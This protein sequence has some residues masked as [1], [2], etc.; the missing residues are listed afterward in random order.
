MPCVVIALA[1]LLIP[2]PVMAARLGTAT[3]P[4]I[5]WLRIALA[6]LLCIALAIAA[7]LTLRRHQ[8]RQD[9]AIL[10]RC[11]STMAQVPRRQITVI[12]TRRVSQH[13]D[14]C[15][16][17][18]HGRAYLLAMGQGH[19]TLLD[20]HSLTPEGNLPEGAA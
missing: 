18:C 2:L 16:I 17:H 6:F 20:Q 9:W 10:T 1:G 19:A 13:G 5:P 14:V 4:G 7:V 12:E 3:S 8:G 11:F 15:L